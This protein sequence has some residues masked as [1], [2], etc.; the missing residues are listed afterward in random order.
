MNEDVQAY[1]KTGMDRFFTQPV[2]PQTLIQ[3]IAEA[4]EL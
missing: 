3:T 1:K 4:M 2:H